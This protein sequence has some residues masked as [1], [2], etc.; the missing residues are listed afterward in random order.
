MLN[1]WNL[2]E[3]LEDWQSQNKQ[4]IANH[5]R[6]N[7]EGTVNIAIETETVQQSVRACDKLPSP[8]SP[9]TQLSI[10]SFPPI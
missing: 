2:R 8:L 10:D 4:Q 6:E 1:F 9:L 3:R 7:V 5:G